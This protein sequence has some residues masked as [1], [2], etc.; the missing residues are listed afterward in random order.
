LGLGKLICLYDDND[1]SIDGHTDLSFTEDVGSRFEAY[2]WH[3]R[4]V[5]EG[6][7]VGSLERTIAEAREETER[8]SLIVVRT[9]IGSGAPTKQDTAE[10]HGA[11]L[12]ADEVKAWKERIGWPESE[13]FI[14]EEALRR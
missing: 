13:F 1:V 8:P 6:D 4:H 14:P 9:H 5:A 2:R 11:P 7:D 3:V 12:G 10:A